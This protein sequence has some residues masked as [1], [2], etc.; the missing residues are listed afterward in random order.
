MVELLDQV[1]SLA[2]GETS[3]NDYLE[4]KFGSEK[5]SKWVEVTRKWIGE[6]K[7]HLHRV[8]H[9]TDFQSEKMTRTLIEGAESI[10][11]LILS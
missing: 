2:C 5:E 4:N 9:H 1:I 6:T 10:I 7:S 8:K 11:V 3:L